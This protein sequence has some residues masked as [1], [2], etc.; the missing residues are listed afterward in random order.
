MRIFGVEIMNEGCGVSIDDIVTEQQH[1][2]VARTII[3]WRPVKYID[4]ATKKPA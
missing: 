3:G 1:T 2:Y 4:P